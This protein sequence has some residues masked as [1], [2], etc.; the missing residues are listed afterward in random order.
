VKLTLEFYPGRAPLIFGRVY[1]PQIVGTEPKWVLQGETETMNFG[2]KVLLRPKSR[3]EVIKKFGLGSD[4]VLVKS[5]IVRKISETG[6]S[7]QADVH[8]WE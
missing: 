1:L 6:D 7:L 4:S 5:L 8:E 2:W 3:D